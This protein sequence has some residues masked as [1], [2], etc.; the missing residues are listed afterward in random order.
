M[1]CMHCIF[2]C[3]QE[4]L[5]LN[6]DLR[7]DRTGHLH[8]HLGPRNHI[9]PNEGWALWRCAKVTTRK[10]VPFPAISESWKIHGSVELPRWIPGRKKHP[11]PKFSRKKHTCVLLVGTSVK[12]VLDFFW[13]ETTMGNWAKLFGKAMPNW[14]PTCRKVLEKDDLKDVTRHMSSDG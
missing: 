3:Q 14:A 9:I 7:C 2:W 11:H 13:V 12:G 4:I 5:G 10:N 8:L 6:E 1:H